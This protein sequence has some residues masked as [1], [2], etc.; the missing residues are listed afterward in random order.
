MAFWMASSSSSSSLLQKC[1]KY[2]LEKRTVL[3]IVLV[4]KTVIR[5]F[6][7]TLYKTQHKTHLLKLLE[8]KASSTLQFIR[9]RIS[10]IAT[11]CHSQIS[12]LYNIS[13][14]NFERKCRV[15]TPI[16]SLSPDVPRKPILSLFSKFSCFLMVL[17]LG[18]FKNIIE[19]RKNCRISPF[20]QN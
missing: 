19:G 8:E 18:I 5:F 9:I 1:W 7:L 3:K 13:S 14:F 6:I 17:F 10:F 12:V 15:H 20:V 16:H 4:K 11:Y 2:I